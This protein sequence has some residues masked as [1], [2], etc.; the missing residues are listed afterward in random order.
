MPIYCGRGP[1]GRACRELA[2]ALVR[3][4]GYSAVACAGHLDAEKTT[5]AGR[6]QYTVTPVNQP[7]DAVRGDGQGTLFDLEPSQ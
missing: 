3:A 1:N 7:A 4:P 6:G 5:A 2:V